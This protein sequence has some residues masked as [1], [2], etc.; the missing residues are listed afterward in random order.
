MST[1]PRKRAPSATM[2]FGALMLPS[3]VQP[4]T[5]STR[6]SAVTSPVSFPSTITFFACTLASMRA[7]VPTRRSPV[8]RIVPFTVPSIRTGSEPVTFPSTTTFGPKKV[9]SN[10]GWGSP[11]RG[12]GRGKE[13]E[14]FR[15]EKVDR[16]NITMTVTAT[17]TVS[18]VT[19]VQVGS[20][21]SGVIS[22]L[23]ADFNSRVH[24]GQLLAELD[25][26]PFQAQVEQRQADVTKARV[27][28]AN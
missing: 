2:I 12:I 9:P 19:T 20:Q 7:F 26:T 5:S 25:P 14:Q 22:R 11:G 4:A 10:T 27:D 23:Y 21:V 1:L 24:R 28:A 16:G 6:S 13:N 17:G 15:I 18:A 3:T 8:R